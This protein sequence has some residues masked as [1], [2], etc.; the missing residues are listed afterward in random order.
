LI[1]KFVIAAASNRC[2][3]HRQIWKR[4]ADLD[5]QGIIDRRRALTVEPY[6]SLA[7]IGFDGP[8]V[9]PYQITSKS[10]EGPVLVALY[11][12][13]ESSILRERPTLQDLG[14]LPNIRF[15]TVID[16]ALARQGLKRS[17]IYVTQ[18]FHLVPRTRSEQISR[19]AIRRSF[20]EVT[21][22]ELQ[23]RKVIALG[24]IAAGECARHHIEHIAVCHPSRRGHTN[25]K[26]ASEIADALAALGFGSAVEDTEIQ[27]D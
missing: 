20:D 19:A 2:L 12:L 26:N 7:E 11:W 1:H 4:A 8:W 27:R 5:Y 17:D 16:G 6:K 10:S 24:D 9:T 22:F 14:Y 23:G 21:R 15:N 3:N 13:D 18:T 25:E